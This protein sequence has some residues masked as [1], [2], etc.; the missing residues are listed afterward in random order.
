MNDASGAD[1][2]TGWQG[3]KKQPDNKL[4]ITHPLVIIR[5]YHLYSIKKQ[6]WSFKVHLKP[7]FQSSAVGG[8]SSY[9]RRGQ[10]KGYQAK[11]EIAFNERRWKGASSKKSNN[12]STTNKVFIVDSASF[13][14]VDNILTLLWDQ[15]LGPMEC[16]WHHCT[17][18]QAIERLIKHNNLRYYLLKIV[19]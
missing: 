19:C 17:Y 5:K 12:N 1:P 13:L 2:G 6:S 8:T 16:Q 4:Q 9:A 15:G 7:I 18:P 14:Q 11:D 3:H 10:T